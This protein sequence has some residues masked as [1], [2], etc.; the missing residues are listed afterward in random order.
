MPK[1][2][3]LYGHPDDPAAFEKYYAHRHLPYA[4]EHMPNVR[5]AENMRIVGTSD[6]TAPAY[7]RIAELTY[8]S[9]DEL[10]AGIA[11]EDGRSVIA[12][13]DNFA[14]GGAALLIGDN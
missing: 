10:R 3:I 9:L 4:G 5:A 14:T 11:S 1:L 8:D 12:D 13:L 6:G 7:Y 2:I